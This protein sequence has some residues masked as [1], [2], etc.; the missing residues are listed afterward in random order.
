[1]KTS[2]WSTLTLIA[3]GITVAPQPLAAIECPVTVTQGDSSVNGSFPQAAK[4]PACTTITFNVSE[5]VTLTKTVTLATDVTVDGNMNGTPVTIQGPIAGP[6]LQLSFTGTILT[7]LHLTNPGKT[8]VRISGSS[9]HVVACAIDAASTGVVITTGTQNLISKT[10]FSHITNTAIRLASGGN[11]LFPAPT[12]TSAR[13]TSTSAWQVT[14]GVDTDAVAVE[15]YEQDSTVPGV[16][17]GKRWVGAAACSGGQ[18]V[19]DNIALATSSPDLSYTG[20]ARDAFNNT[21]AFGPTFQPSSDAAFM[22]VVDPDGDGALDGDDNCPS[23]ANNNQSDSDLDGIGDACEVDTDGDTILDDSDNCPVV[24]NPEQMDIDGDGIGDLC[25]TDYD[26][27]GIPNASDNCAQVANVEQTDTD[28]DG[29]GDACDADPDG[30][31]SA[32]IGGATDNCPAVSNADQQDSDSDGVG[33]ACDNCLD[34]ANPQQLDGDQDGFGDVCDIE[35][36]AG[37]G[38]TGNGPLS[39]DVAAPLQDITAA[40]GTGGC[41]LLPSHRA[42]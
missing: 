40:E 5:P 33:D 26:Y 36:S 1:M 7:N 12:F 16:P 19:V 37:G 21:S 8:A 9:N 13:Q 32:I 35:A 11:Y 29:V 23:V 4:T 39:P 25:E 34:I 14:V 10:V 17:Q 38:T 20:I 3:V 30:D 2:S 42:R 18:C 41:S 31:V 27:D 24:T 22:S 28:N 6:L 15:V